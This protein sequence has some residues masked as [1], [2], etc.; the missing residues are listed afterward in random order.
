MISKYKYMNKLLNKIKNVFYIIRNKILEQLDIFLWSAKDK[1]PKKLAEKLVR[2]VCHSAFGFFKDEEVRKMLNFSSLEQGERD[3]IFN[4][5]ELS[6]LCLIMFMVE[7]RADLIE[8]E[9][10]L[11]IKTKE[12]I[13]RSF[14]RWL[15]DLGIEKHYL[16][17][18]KK[19]IEMR[20]KEYKKDQPKI[21]SIMMQELEESSDIDPLFLDVYTLV[22]SVSMGSLFHIRRGKTS[23]KDPL[24]KHLRIWLLSLFVK[25]ENKMTGPWWRRFF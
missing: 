1:N 9:K 12:E 17:L 10:E 21:K 24:Y 19:L 6:G 15:S 25:I 11:W 5:L 8:K 23:I 14:I 16:N 2:M 13:P 18:W 3:R 7:D 22:Q 4:E 20:Y